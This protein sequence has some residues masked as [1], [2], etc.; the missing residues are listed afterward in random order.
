MHILQFIILQ[1]FKLFL[2][3]KPK[4]KLYDINFFYIQ[5]YQKQLALAK[6]IH[7]KVRKN[8]VFVFFYNKNVKIGSAPYNFLYAI[9]YLIFLTIRIFQVFV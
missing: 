7:D 1:K 6:Q 4:K 9:S 5:V 2:L 8:T 3:G